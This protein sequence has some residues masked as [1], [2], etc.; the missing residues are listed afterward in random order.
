MDNISAYERDFQK[1]LTRVH[2]NI[3]PEDPMP[4]TFGGKLHSKSLALSPIGMSTLDQT[5]CI[6]GYDFPTLDFCPYLPPL[7]SMIAH[8]FNNQDDVLGAS[9]IILNSVLNATQFTPFSVSFEETWTYFS[10]TQ[11][12]VNRMGNDFGYLLSNRLPKLH[13]HL[14]AI[15]PNREQPVWCEWLTDFFIPF[16]PQAILWRILD[17]FIIEGYKTLFRV[18]IAVLTFYREHILSCKNNA[19]LIKA[20]KI[21]SI[22]E[23]CYSGFLKSVWHVSFSR[24]DLV[25]SQEDIIL[26]NQP[27]D[28][29][30][31]QYMRNTPKMMDESSV[32]EDFHW[33][34]LW[35]V[36]Y[37][38][39]II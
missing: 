9:A 37:K 5:L 35:S 33:I 24:A 15:L 28:S 2:G 21:N 16:L 3:I 11:K 32:L 26:S 13:K 31:Y 19:Q 36:L 12:Q 39:N 10:T 1:A 29:P 38:L 8:I 17:S 25:P 22:S 7:I 18:G 20:I 4:P 30:S 14:L 34:A 27:A 23:E 6:L